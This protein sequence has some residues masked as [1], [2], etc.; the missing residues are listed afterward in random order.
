MSKELLIENRSWR[1]PVMNNLYSPGARDEEMQR[2]KNVESF[3]SPKKFQ[4]FGA[5]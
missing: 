3:Q 1:E 5:F 4:H 2:P